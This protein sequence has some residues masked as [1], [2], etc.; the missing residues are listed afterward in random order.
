MIDR[1]LKLSNKCYKLF[2]FS[3]GEHLMS[4]IKDFDIYFLDIK[5]DKLTGIEAA[6]KSD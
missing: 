2:E 5:M 6:K 3:S 4:S 1:F